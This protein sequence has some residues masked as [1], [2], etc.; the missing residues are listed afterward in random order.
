APRERARDLFALAFRRSRAALATLRARAR[1]CAP[2][3]ARQMLDVDPRRAERRETEH[4]V[5]ELAY[6][7]W[8]RIGR[9]RFERARRELCVAP[10]RRE[11]SPCEERDVVGALAERRDPD[12]EDAQ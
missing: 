2:H 4:V 7:A 5:L 8:P 12:L 11:E 9:E 10:G 1:C 6:V 3:L